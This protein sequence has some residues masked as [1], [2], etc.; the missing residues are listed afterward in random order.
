LGWG[1]SAA[2]HEH[3]DGKLA[4]RDAGAL[5]LVQGNSAIITGTVDVTLNPLNFPDHLA[6][7]IV[8]WG[9]TAVWSFRGF[10]GQGEQTV[11]RFARIVALLVAA[12]F[13]AVPLLAAEGKKDAKKLV[14]YQLQVPKEITLTA[15]QQKKLDELVATYGPK[16]DA[17]QKQRGTF[18]SAEQIKAGSEAHQTAEAAGKSWKEIQ[19]A[20][21][22]AMKLTPEQKTKLDALRKESTPITREIREKLLGLLTPEQKAQWEKAAQKKKEAAKK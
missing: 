7:M 14:P 12:L 21:D 20:T 8:P 4:R 22:D 6:G 10:C 19:Q 5:S 9:R 16:L 15:E 13:V 3:P 11:S 17:I 18:L 2:E 1:C